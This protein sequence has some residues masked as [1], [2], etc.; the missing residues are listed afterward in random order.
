MSKGRG[1]FLFM[2]V[3]WGLSA[4]AQFVTVTNALSYCSGF[5]AKTTPAAKDIYVFTAGHCV[6]SVKPLNDPNHVVIHKAL[7]SPKTMAAVDEASGE[8][9]TLHATEIL[10]GTYQG[11][12]FAIFSLAEKE[13][14]LLAAGLAP[15]I[16]NSVKPAE[17]TA[18]RVLNSKT[19]EMQSCV[20]EKNLFSLVYKTSTWRWSSRLSENCKLAPGWSGAA[21]VDSAGGRVLGLIGGGNDKGD[22][23]DYCQVDA[24]GAQLALLGRAY[25]T[26]LEFLRSCLDRNGAVV[27]ERCRLRR[28]RLS[29]R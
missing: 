20:V 13:Q 27:P 15:L 22:C 17:G 23:T 25:F 11:A 24:S 12:D 5:L 10:Y 21:V 14:D 4:K 6:P 16:L 18:V 28:S 8:T 29:G 26:R 9:A 1:V 7:V 2:V 19:L 3:L